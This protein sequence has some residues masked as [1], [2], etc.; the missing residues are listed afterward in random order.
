MPI[1]RTAPAPALA[2]DAVAV[3]LGGWCAH[4]PVPAPAEGSDDLLDLYDGLGPAWRTHEAWLRVVAREWGWTPRYRGP[5]GVLRFFGEACA[6][7]CDSLSVDEGGSEAC[8]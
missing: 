7:G 8:P 3:L 5:D 6:S 4:P 2:L 1:R